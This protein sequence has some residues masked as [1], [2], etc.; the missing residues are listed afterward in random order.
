MH[1]IAGAMVKAPYRWSLLRS[2]SQNMIW[3]PSSADEL[4]FSLSRRGDFP[5]FVGRADFRKNFHRKPTTN[6]EAKGE[7]QERVKSNRAK[8]SQFFSCSAKLL[9]S[10]I[11]PV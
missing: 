4:N 5:F 8:L 6:D 9:I 7:A 1:A 10:M 11:D 3:S 2:V